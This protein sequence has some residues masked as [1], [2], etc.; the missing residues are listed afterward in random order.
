MQALLFL[1]LIFASVV[2][3]RTINILR[4]PEQARACLLVCMRGTPSCCVPLLR[5]MCTSLCLRH[6]LEVHAIAVIMLRLSLQISWRHACSL[7]A[8]ACSATSRVTLEGTWLAA[9]H[10]SAQVPPL[11]CPREPAP[12]I[13]KLR[14]RYRRRR[15]GAMRA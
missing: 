8:R 14:R 1:V 4:Q 10:T 2:Q 7:H 5:S 12:C 13:A 9:L 3:G 6:V 11:G 15:C